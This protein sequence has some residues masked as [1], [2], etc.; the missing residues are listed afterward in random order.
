M[1]YTHNPAR[2][3]RP[4]AVAPE[5]VEEDAEPTLRPPPPWML[6]LAGAAVAALMGGLLGGFLNI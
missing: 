5:P 1:I 4:E 2:F 6:M 3:V